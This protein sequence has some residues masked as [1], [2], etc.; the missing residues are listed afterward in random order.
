ML[1]ATRVIGDAIGY[2]LCIFIYIAYILYKHVDAFSIS[3]QRGVS[4]HE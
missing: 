4:L 1:S 2:N 3:V